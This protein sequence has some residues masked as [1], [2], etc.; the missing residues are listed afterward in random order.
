MLHSTVFKMDYEFIG[1]AG[2]ID[3]Y[4]CFICKQVVKDAVQTVCCGC[5]CCERCISE[6]CPCCSKKGDSVEYKTDLFVNRHVKD[7]KIKCVHSG[8]GCNWV[9][10]VCD[11]THH[12][13]NKCEVEK[14]ECSNCGM[15][16]STS[17]RKHHTNN[18]CVH[19]LTECEHS[20]SKPVVWSCRI[21]KGCVRKWQILLHNY[22]RILLKLVNMFD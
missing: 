17:L 11:I 9:G 15:V 20:Y 5:L 12:L 2:L 19:R 16:T 8:N 4:R 13:V 3:K 18:V 1:D 7:L 6:Q 21:H 10:P 22:K 14:I